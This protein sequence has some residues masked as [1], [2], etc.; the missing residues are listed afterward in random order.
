[1]KTVAAVGE[2]LSAFTAKHPAWRLSD[3]ARELEWDLATTH[4]ITNALSE[5]RLLERRT[6][7][8]YQLGSLTTELSAVYI[9]QEPARRELLDRIEQLADATG[10]TTQIGVLNGDRALIVESRISDRVLRAAAMW[11]QRLPLHASAVGKAILAQLSD[12]RISELLPA[13]LE[14]ITGATIT[15]RDALLGEVERV[16]ESAMAVADGE[17]ANGLYAIAIALP[18]GH[19]GSEPA[20]LTC[21]GPTPSLMADEWDLAEQT[22][23]ALNSTWNA[24]AALRLL[25][26]DSGE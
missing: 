20:A 5:I 26:P 6:D 11:G 10:L 16:R 3:L 24:P 19:Y 8:S 9:S 14:A 2:M 12:Q 23:R 13:Q 21:V 7:D 1:M 4:R 15:D 18:T 22:F 17:L 25:R